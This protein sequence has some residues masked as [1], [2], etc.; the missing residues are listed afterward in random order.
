M[1]EPQSKLLLVD[2]DKELATMLQE[3]LNIQGFSVITAHDGE[4][5]YTMLANHQPDLIILD[6]MLPGISGFDVLKK[7]RR[8]RNTP[9][10]MLTARGEEP[11]R[12]LGLMQGADDYLTKPFSPLELSARITSVLR[13][14]QTN[15]AAHSS[16]LV[17]GP[18][19]LS[20]TRKELLIHDKP[21]AVT[22]AEMRILEQLLRHPDEV[23]SRSILTELALNRPLEAFDRSID[24]LISKLRKKLAAAGIN[25]ECIKA[26]RGHGYVFDKESTEI[27][28]TQ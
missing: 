28:E 12:I 1:S 24:T 10:I 13:R 25:K 17:A 20:I 27:D 18:I 4:T 15:D 7:I 11:D 3:F 6:V 19:V 5:G 22:A 2:D 8:E 23:M 21:I 9:V 26:L 16:E 14:V